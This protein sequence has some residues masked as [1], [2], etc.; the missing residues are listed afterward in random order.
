MGPD[1][2][3]YLRLLQQLKSYNNVPTEL[4]YS[5]QS[6]TSIVYRSDVQN[7]FSEP[8]PWIGIYIALASLFCII[9]IVADLLHGLRNRKL[10]FPCK[11]FTLNAASLSVIAIAMK[12]P[13]DLNNS[14]PGDVDQ[15]A[16]L[17]S[18][19][20]M[21]TMMSNLLPA[22][23]ILDSKELV[24][25][26]IALGVLV[27]TIVVNV[28]IQ[29]KT[30]VVSSIEV[31][32]LFD[33]D[34]YS[35]SVS[36][37][38]MP[39]AIIYVAMLLMLLIMH[40]CSALAI[41]KSKQILEM[42]YQAAH[43]T[44]MKDKELQQPGRLSV[45]KIKQLVSNYWIM[46]STGN[47]QFFTACSATSCASGVISA[48][49][50]VL[51]VIVILFIVGSLGDFRSDYK[52]SALVILI[53]QFIG[54]IVGTMAPLSRCFAA[55]SFKLSIKWIWNNM[56]VFK[57]ESYWTQTLYDLKESTM[58][59]LSCSR[60]F[61]IFVENTKVIVL[62]F[63]IGFQKTVVVACKMIGLIPIFIVI[64]I[65]ICS[66]C[67][68]WLKSMFNAFGIVL[69]KEPE[70]HE[71]NKILSHYVLQLQEDAELA[72]RTLKRISYSFERIIKKAE[73]QQPYNLMKLV[74]GYRGFRRAE[75]FDS[76]HVLSLLLEESPS[77]WSLP[78]VTLT[79]MAIS[80]PNI[81]KDR[82]DC[83]LSGVS[84]GMVYVTI[85]EDSLNATDDHVIIQKAA[86][87]LWLEVEIYQKWLG[88]KLR[89]P[90]PLANTAGQIL[91]WLRDTAKNMVTRVESRDTKGQNDSSKFWSISASSMYRITEMILHSNHAHVDK[92]SPEELFEQLSSMIADIF[93]ACLTNLPQVIAMKC[94]SSEI[95]KREAS[96]YAAAQI[97]G[98]TM[99]ILNTIQDSELPSLNPD[100]LVFIVDKLGA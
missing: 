72:E 47:P 98:E 66:C 95:E 57:V 59:F 49:S 1:L 80:L 16:K 35:N 22:L 61:K 2:I 5:L 64:C 68:K 37:Y 34:Y 23:A 10:W 85:V 93:V 6:Y 67:W 44:A 19:G 29:I 62:S 24:T 58:P 14:M 92:V 76:H 50:T 43:E 7:R 18:M 38:T 48:I 4:I 56:N 30:G 60:K 83:L 79:T 99:Q 74:E 3:E 75:K 65:F 82:V 90:V 21:C 11:Y 51:H 86:Q 52:W 36:Y 77:C 88:N 39:I 97:L 91:L 20:F 87:T 32:Y 8:M 17:G 96:V 63:C 100:D 15:A 53:T 69:I 9:A 40:A 89:K 94:H 70:Q 25:N 73:K 42:K 33:D 45:D 28:C 27:V 54:S 46:A 71:T 13:V 12:L 55:L 41:L 81:K 26:I 84:E 78:L 31:W